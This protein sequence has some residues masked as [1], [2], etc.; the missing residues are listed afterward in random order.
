MSGPTATMTWRAGWAWTTVEGEAELIGPDDPAEGVD[1][2]G[3]R[4]L[5]R[6]IYS[7]SGGGEHEDWAEYDRVVAIE[8]RVAVL[9][10]PQRIYVNP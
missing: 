9:V 3:V 8:R 7:A 2:E 5:L 6:A 10:P 4:T 1:A